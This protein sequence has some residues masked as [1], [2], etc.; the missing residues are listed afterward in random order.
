MFKCVLACFAALLC[1]MGTALGQGLEIKEMDIRSNRYAHP[2]KD[3][4]AVPNML[5]TEGFALMCRSREAELWLSESHHTLR[6][7][8]RR[9]GYVWGAIPLEEARNLNSSWKSYAGSIVSIEC[10]DNKANEKRYG[11]RDNADVTYRPLSNG[12][13]F[14]AD[15]AALGIA[16]S[17]KITLEGERLMFELIPD[18]LAETGAFQLKSLAFMPYL[19]AVYEDETPGW[20]LLPDGPGA[21]MRFMKPQSYIAGYDKKIYGKDP[22]VDVTSDIQPLNANRPDDYVVPGNAVLFPVYAIAHG[23]GQNGLLAVTEGGAA[24]ASIVAT[25]AGLGNTKYNSIMTRFDYRQKYFRASNRSGSG[26]LVPQESIN[27]FTPKQSFYL[28]QGGEADYDRMAVYYR[29]MLIRQGALNPLG[30]EPGLR[31]EVVGADVKKRALSL[32]REVFTTF[33]EAAKITQAL[34][35][36]GAYPIEL[37]MRG[38]KKNNLPGEGL[39]PALGTSEAWAK[40]N[41]TLAGKGRL[42]IHLDPVRAN[43]DQ[44]NLR[45]SSVTAMGLSPAATLRAGGVYPETYYYRTALVEKNIQNHLGQMGGYAVALDGLGQILTSDYT[46]GAEVTRERA[47]EQAQ[48]LAAG[49][50]AH[51]PLAL[52]APNQPLWAY[53]GRFYDLPLSSDQLLF[54]S[55][56]VPFLPIVLKGSMTLYAPALN[57][58][59]F[60]RDRILRMIEYG[61][62]PSFVVINA[63]SEA[64]AQ[65]PLEDWYS[66]CFS[67][68]QN[69]IIETCR[70]VSAVLGATRGKAIQSHQAV[71]EGRVIVGYEGGMRLYI[72]YTDA[73]WESDAGSIPAHDAKLLTGGDEHEAARP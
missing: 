59:L 60:T 52:Y 38:V 37:V 51:A 18:T 56:T 63:P 50:H 20:F 40:L 5:D 58:G 32:S 22:G 16:F 19:G 26:M 17:G 41:E 65:T 30:E 29:E 8:D 54:E 12:F 44:I 70:Y 3:M 27:V 34:L 67:D 15:F 14:E 68:W 69:D 53:A 36:A 21:L 62:F 73:A 71:E 42:R 13:A 39:N 25:P 49:L 9:S 28:R 10:Y 4:R 47:L 61:A 31:L 1:L 66:A 48:T 6:I 55:D 72:N 43:K 35:D 11:M 2:H 33:D 7:V 57:T 64:L 46:A 23:V 45:L 24:Y